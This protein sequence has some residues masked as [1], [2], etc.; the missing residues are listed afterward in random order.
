MPPLMRTAL[1]PISRSLRAATSMSFSESIFMSASSSASG[2]L[3]VRRSA[4]GRMCQRKALT[5]S[6]RRSRC[7]LWLTQTGSTT[8][9]NSR[10]LQSGFDRF[11]DF[12]GE[13]HTGLGRGDGEAFPDRFELK[14]HKARF[15][16]MDTRDAHAVLRGQGGNDAHPEPTDNSDGFEVGLNA[17]AAAGVGTGDGEDTWRSR[18]GKRSFDGAIIC[19]DPSRRETRGHHTFPHPGEQAPSGYCSGSG[20]SRT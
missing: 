12:G 15:R 2:R 7:P 13:Q 20:P 14:P 18:H 17:R 16:G 11:N 9:G 6:S 19:R 4:L 5:A 8:S 1:G 10:P 3:G